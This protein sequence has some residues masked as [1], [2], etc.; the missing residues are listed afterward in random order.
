MPAAPWLWWT[1]KAPQPELSGIQLSG[2]RDSPVIT[3]AI[4]GGLGRD[5]EMARRLALVKHLIEQP[6]EPQDAPTDG[7][8]LQYS[9]GAGGAVR[10]PAAPGESPDD[11]FEVGLVL[12][13]P[14]K[15]IATLI[16]TDRAGIG[17][18]RVTKADGA[19]VK[20]LPGITAGDVMEWADFAAPKGRL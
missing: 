15:A 5:G 20:L 19:E 17:D 9:N 11:K 13:L 16:A 2:D 8:P 10:T 4:T 7:R 1:Y 3:E 12:D 6:Q 14:D 18:W